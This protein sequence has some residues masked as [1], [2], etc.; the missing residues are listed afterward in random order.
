MIKH[1]SLSPIVE[2]VIVNQHSVTKPKTTE[3]KKMGMRRRKAKEMRKKR[4]EKREIIGRDRHT[5]N[6]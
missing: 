5:K 3:T 2:V 6:R 1:V 4:N